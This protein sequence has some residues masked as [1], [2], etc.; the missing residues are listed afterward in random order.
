MVTETVVLDRADNSWRSIVNTGDYMVL[1]GHN[2]PF[3]LRFG[4]NSTSE[5]MIVEKGESLKVEET[6]Y[7]RPVTIVND[8]RQYTTLYVHKG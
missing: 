4:V 1:A 5:G 8:R 6:V 7:V 2:G 3:R